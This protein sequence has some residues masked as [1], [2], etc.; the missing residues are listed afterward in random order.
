MIEYARFHMNLIP[1]R[2]IGE[3]IRAIFDGSMNLS[4]PIQN[5]FGNLL[6]FFPLG[7]YLPLF[8]KKLKSWKKYMVTIFIILLGIEL[9]Q[10]FTRR[11]SFD[12]DDL[13]LNVSGAM[14]GCLL[15]KTRIL[16]WLEKVY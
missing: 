11:G 4:I 15:W 12:V 1:F 5:L 16:Q 6:L 10:I 14:I 8:F 2:T 13:I 9:V 3:Y 7:I